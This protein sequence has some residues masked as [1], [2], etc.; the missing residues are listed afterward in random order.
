MAREA[1]PTWFFAMVVVRLGRRF[2]VVHERKHGQLWYLPAGRVE[3]GE[4][5]V[6]AAV[7]ET[8]EETGVRIIVESLLRVEH[9]PSHGGARVRVFLLAR[10]SD[11]TAPRTTPNEHTLEA[12]W[13]TLDELTSL[14]LRDVEVREVFEY[15]AR[16]G[17]VYP[18]SLLTSEGAP[19]REPL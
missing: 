10:P 11:D 14:P 5:L 12:R 18:L 6:E 3:P 8:L 7:R 17:P 15:V 1:I 9:A 2:L 16:G 19:W 4:T 13:V